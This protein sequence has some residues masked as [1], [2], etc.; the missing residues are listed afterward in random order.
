MDELIVEFL[1]ET[2][3]SLE[4]LDVDLVD[5]EQN[6][7]NKDLLEKIFR[8][9]H[10]I[11]GTC[12]FLSLPNLEKLAHHAENVLGLFRD[13]NLDVTADYV[14]LIFESIDEIKAIV[15]TIE[16]TGAE[17]DNDYTALIAKLDAAFEGKPPP[18][19]SPAPPRAAESLP[20]E[21][22]KPHKTQEAQT[23]RV[24]V[25]VLEDLM[26]MVSELVLTRNQLLQ[27]TRAQGE[28]PFTPPL[29]RLNLIASELQEGVMKTRMQPIGNAW[30]MLPRIVRDLAI[31]LG[32]KIEL[33][34]SGQET[35]LDRQ[36]L[37]MIKDP[38]TH[39]IRNSG[40]HGI[41]SPAERRAA[42]KTETG[43]IHLNAY[44]EGGY[45]IIKIA[46]DGKGL[47]ADKIKNKI[48]QNNLAT[49]EELA[50][51][52]LQQI[53]QFIFKAGFS[54]AETV[55]SIS[56]RG[57]GM[58]VVRTNIE[59]IGGTIDL[60]SV[61]GEGSTFTIKIPLTLAIIHALIIEVATE[62]YAIS[63]LCVKELV[64]VSEQSAQKIEYIKKTPVFRL[65][66]ELLPLVCL[67]ELLCLTPPDHDQTPIDNQ[68]RYIIVTETE[69]QSFG[70]IVDRVL[71]TEEIVVKPVSR[72]LRSVDVFSG[73]TILGDGA[74]IMI[75][76]TVGIARKLGPLSAVQKGKPLKQTTTRNVGDTLSL[77]LF[78]AGDATPKAVPSALIARIE[79]I[80]PANIEY[81]GGQMMIQ[82]RGALMPLTPFNDAVKMDDGKDKHVLVFTDNAQSMGV[83]VDHIVDITEENVNMQIDALQDGLLGSAIINN[84]A[85]DVVDM[86]YFLNRVNH[87]WFKEHK[88]ANDD[89]PDA[90]TAQNQAKKHILLIDNG[91]FFC[92][93]LSPILRIAGYDI[94]TRDTP[95][96]A[97]KLCSKGSMFD[98]IVS[99]MHI[100]DMD[101]F[102]FIKQI[103]DTNSAWSDVPIVAL[104]ARVTPQDRAR[105][106]ES[107]FIDY[108]AKFDTETL[109]RTL[110]DTLKQPD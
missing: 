51:M 50:E 66:E 83:I 4:E 65:R 104:S 81:S 7:N 77:L 39:M 34:M 41:E 74:V 25:D 102:A 80:N 63:Q 27:I 56:G 23:L 31:E 68:S 2:N 101:S 26:T 30:T 17:P 94:T 75:L 55:T 35:E 84:H 6:P 108:I 95:T 62:R 45:V 90:S 49:A 48:I 92:K 9:M 69:G 28:T 100:D 5:F 72:M 24:H 12:G 57:V 61:E 46:D 16:Q 32:K 79:T 99:H 8:L 3:E 105:A 33:E 91:P 85:T 20:P 40:D 93:M 103:K 60:Q 42:G 107:G 71:N 38:L 88:T 87:N 10:T 44:H 109:L 82:Y 89:P 47:S 29:Q 54:T 59:K 64:M 96:N 11:K 67:S 37:D 53:Q 19:D 98:L 18:A 43:T 110:S 76:D 70:I 13:G 73:S 1:A 86:A 14:T 21:D 36:V 58:D 15:N 78:K 52:S 97:L 106:I 22:A